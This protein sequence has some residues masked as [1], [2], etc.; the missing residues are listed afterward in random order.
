MGAHDTRNAEEYFQQTVDVAKRASL[1]RMQAEGYLHLAEIYEHRSELDKALGV[2]DS[3][4]GQAR[5]VEEGF[6]LPL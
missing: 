5:R 4:I 3:G 1:P 2:I 6:D